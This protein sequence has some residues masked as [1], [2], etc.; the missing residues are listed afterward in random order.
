MQEEPGPLWVR[1]VAGARTE[2]SSRVPLGGLNLEDVRSEVGKDL[3][4]VRTG[5]IP[6]EVEDTQSVEWCGHEDLLTGGETNT[7][8]TW[9]SA[10]LLRGEQLRPHNLTAVKADAWNATIRSVEG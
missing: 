10:P 6:R 5:D 9:H 1:L 7:D 8:L 2:T 3:G 4:G